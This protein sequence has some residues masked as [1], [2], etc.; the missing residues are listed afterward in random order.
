MELTPEQWRAP[1]LDP[2]AEAEARLRESLEAFGV[3]AG[4]TH[5]LDPDQAKQVIEAP[6]EDWMVFLHP[7]QRSVVVKRFEGPARVRGS[8]GTGKTVVG[9]HRAAELATRYRDEG[10]VL[11]T[12]YINSLPPVLAHL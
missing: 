6:I 1:S 4:F 7:E 9:L 5:L 10:A 11:F 12:T 3:L 8:A 2:E